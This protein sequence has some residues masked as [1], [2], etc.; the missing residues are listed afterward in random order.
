MVKTLKRVFSYA[1]PYM[2]YFIMTL[3]FAALGV[4]LSLAV[5]VFIGEAVDCCIGKGAVDFH[6]LTK[7]ITLLASMV[8][9]ST[10]FQ[11]LMS[12]CTN[13][14]AFLTIR[15]IRSDIF[16]KLER[17]PLRYIDG[18]TKGELT[19][20]VINDIEIISDGLLQGFTQFFSGIITI[21]GTLVFMMV[22][23]YR[24]AIVVVI[25]TPLSFIAASKITKASHDSYM[26]QSKLRGEMVGL[27]EEM[28]G[29]QKIVKA[30][31]YGKRAEAR[32]DVINKA[33]GDIGAKAT[34]FSSM[35][36]PTTRFVNGLIY[37]AV[38][39]L[40][41]LGVVGKFPVIGAMTV[42][43]LSSFLA[44]SNQY[45]KPFNEISGVFAELQ[46]AVASAE[47]VFAVLDEEEV[48]D[49]SDKAVLDSCDGT[50]RFS[51]VFF[52]YSSETKLI[53]N[54]TLDVKSGQRIAIVGPTG[55]GKSTI[56]N[57]LLRFYDID[58]GR[59]EI[60][61]RNIND[62]TRDSLRSCFGMVLQE[63]WIFTGT[64]A[65]NIAY[66]A[67]DATREQIIAAAKSV[68]AH[69]FIKRLPDGY[70]TVI[71]EDCGL[72]QGQKQ[73]ICIARIMLMD[74]PVLILDEATSS[75][76]LRTE[77]RVQRAFTKLMEGR[78]SFVIAHRLSTIKNSD[79]IL[80]MKHGNI[81]EQGSHDQLLAEG[82]FYAELYNSQFAS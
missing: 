16:C 20:R 24:I 19:S 13:K 41:A 3:V 74:P 40:G 2:K 75:I 62:V 26:K 14:L 36:N 73:L 6:K 25:L 1:G 79:V 80:V 11:W 28:A 82:G 10:L 29:N 77:L 59:I 42:G 8:V 54:F 15:D 34:F 61:G 63:T 27:A 52:S 57:L 22:I 50:L 49:D 66:G 55:C 32:F 44:Y 51:D 12:L 31:V 38:G 78:T 67:P 71:N 45:T 60:S 56:I 21:I 33:Y 76:D 35:T 9:A 37:A 58:S 81:I 70:D 47:R 23:N 4:S 7:I 69:G 72:S 48:S 46:N 53:E 68:Y 18:H 43:K 39:L 5:P 64:V 17:V 65:E 30:F